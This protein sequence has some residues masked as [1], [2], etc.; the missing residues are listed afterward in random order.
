MILENVFNTS[1]SKNLLMSY[2]TSPFIEGTQYSHTNTLEA[3]IIAEIFSEFGYNIDVV[4]FYDKVHFDN[5]K[6]YDLVFGFGESFC[7]SFYWTDKN[8]FRIFYGTGCYVAFQNYQTLKRVYD[9]YLKRG[10]LIPESGRLVDKTWSL[11][12]H[13]ADAL[14]ILGNEHTA[15]TYS[16]TN[17]KGEIYSMPASYFD[18]YKPDLS[19][20]DYSKA[21]KHFLWFGSSGL[22]HKGLDLVLEIFSKRRDIYLHVC[23]PIKNEPGFEKL[24]YKELYENPNIICYD[25]IDINSDLFIE[26]LNQC[27]FTI[28]P[29][30]SEGC[31]PSVITTMGNGGLIPLITRACGINSPVSNFM[32]DYPNA[33]NVRQAIDRAIVLSPSELLNR[34]IECL[35]YARKVHSI[36]Q[37]RN[38]FSEIINTV[39][40]KQ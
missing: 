13:L 28:F 9:V 20:K 5:I 2:I 29:S 7:D 18:V 15:Q 40:S 26:I 3:R 32:I 30:A 8:V 17:I 31:S 27:A 6:K 34:S 22:I 39:L 14:I 25:F 16:N 24:Y 21:S 38:N 37:F 11:H 36:D 19:A 23:G 10:I 1:F 35:E 4:Q 33:H 12:S